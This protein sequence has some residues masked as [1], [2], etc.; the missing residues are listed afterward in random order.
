MYNS[1]VE[2]KRIRE[3]LEERHR[4]LTQRNWEKRYSCKLAVMQNSDRD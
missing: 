1:F 4:N 3:Q 2:D